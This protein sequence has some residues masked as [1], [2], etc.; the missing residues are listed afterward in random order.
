MHMIKSLSWV[1][2]YRNQALE[3]VESKI[4]L[5]ELKIFLSPKIKKNGKYLKN[6]PFFEENPHDQIS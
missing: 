2:S 3:E 6:Y 1:I 4:F 5:S